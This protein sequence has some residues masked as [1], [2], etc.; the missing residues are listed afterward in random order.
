MTKPC[1]VALAV[2]ASVGL[3]AAAFAGPL[4]DPPK[5]GDTP[6]GPVRP[7][8][9]GKPAADGEK[10]VPPATLPFSIERAHG[11]LV[12]LRRSPMRGPGSLVQRRKEYARL[13]ERVL[14]LP[15]VKK[16]A[17]EE[18]FQ[19]GELAVEGERNSE[20]EGFY[21]AYLGTEGE[22][23]FES[24]AR[25]GL[26]RSLA[27]RDLVDPSGEALAAME[28]ALPESE[29]L[30][31]AGKLHGDALVRAGDHK[32]AVATYGSAIDRCAKERD[33]A[34]RVNLAQSVATV[35]MADG[36]LDALRKTISGLLEM[37]RPNHRARLQSLLDR[38]DR[39]GTPYPLPKLPR[40]GG[41]AP[42]VESI[43]G[44]VVVLHVFSWWME[45]RRDELEAWID[46]AG[47]SELL[48]I[49][50]TRTTGWDATTKTFKRGSDPAK[51]A[52]HILELLASLGWKGA[53]GIG[54]GRN[55]FDS[56]GVR[57]IPMDVVLDREGKVRF[58]R[59]SGEVGGVLARRVA[60]RLLAAGK[61][62][63]PKE[64]GT[65]TTDETSKGAGEPSSEEGEDR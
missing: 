46:L 35:H 15:A 14:A 10:R 4:Q 58:M 5:D 41:T 55:A 33:A 53:L 57:G 61:D 23:A 17:G 13:A 59:A 39:I 62:G 42:T 31:V 1:T 24:E 65:G 19:L 20:A 30:P 18:L 63:K 6:T 51:E 11:K 50:V 43:K 3:S 56:M 8:E 54:N 22:K 29:L 34:L 25:M 9:G 27:A 64:T 49:P 40:W 36:D 52:A 38:A 12:R 48:F 37:A 21:R 16:A 32:A 60:G 45:S 47:G 26:V 7:P 28:K 2:L 44:R